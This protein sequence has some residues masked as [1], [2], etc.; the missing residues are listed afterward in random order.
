MYYSSSGSD[1]HHDRH[2]YHPYRISDRG[3]SLDKFKKEKTPTFDGEM[4]KS[5]DAEAWLFGMRKFFR[6]HEYLENMKAKIAT[7]I[8]KGITDIW[9]EDVKNVK[10]MNEDDLT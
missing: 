1:M 7:I 4:K 10:G 3:Y 5:Q 8:L 9:W 6:L 2:R